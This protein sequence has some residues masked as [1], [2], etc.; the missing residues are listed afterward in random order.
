MLEV[1]NAT[2]S[3]VKDGRT[4]PAA[5]E[6]SLCAREGELVVVHGPSGSG[7]STLLMMMGGMLPPDSG[8]VLYDGWEVYRGSP[9]KRNR[10]RKH[11]VGFVFQRFLLMP[12]LSVRDNIGM[13]LSLQ[14]RRR[15]ASAAVGELA[16]SLGIEQRLG[17]R[18]GELSVGEQQRVALARA[19]V[20]GQKLI[21][22]DEPTGNLDPPNAEMI[23][24][25]LVHESRQGRIVV[26]VTHDPVLLEIATKRL[27]L[28]S[29]RL[30][31]P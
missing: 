27:R 18:P 8:G 7:K 15:E 10:Y 20:G 17:H 16:R 14:G 2:K 22:A 29:G 31:E 1:R 24:Q 21:L 28:E 6:L 26:L 19:L 11:T 23:A 12:Y 4:V 13:P 3:Y 30:V 5:R 9:A 25:R